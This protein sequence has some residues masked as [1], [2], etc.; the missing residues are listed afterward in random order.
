MQPLVHLALVVVQLLFASLAI[1][2]RFVLPHFPA[3]ALVTVRVLGATA[4]SPGTQYRYRRPVGSGSAG[5]AQAGRP[6]NAGHCSQPDALPLRTAAHHRHQ[7]HHP[8]D[9]RAGLYRA[10]LGAH[11]SRAPVAAQVRWNRAGR[12]GSDLPDR[13][14]PYLPCTRRRA[15]ECPHRAG[16]DLLCGVLPLFEV[17]SQ[18]VRLYHRQLLRHVLRFLL[19]SPVRA[20]GSPA[21]GPICE[22]V[23]PCGS[24]LPTLSSSRQY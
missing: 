23:V 10:R 13:P 22:S 15:G 1:A 8:G 17:R 7:R 18:P 20:D 2:G 3:G 4:G 5:P 19:R 16:N 9:D 6:G 14:G 12:N 21:N 24:G 11:R